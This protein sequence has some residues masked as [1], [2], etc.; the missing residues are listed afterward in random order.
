MACGLDYGEPRPRRLWSF[1]RGHGA[2][3][4]YSVLVITDVHL[5]TLQWP[6]TYDSCDY[7]TAP[8]QSVNGLPIATT[9]AGDQYNENLFSFLPGQKLSRCTC[10]GESHP[11]PMH[12]DG[13]YVGRSAPEIDVLEA[14]VRGLCQFLR[15]R[16]QIL[17]SFRS[18]PIQ[19]LV[20][21]WARSPNLVSLL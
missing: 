5:L 11:G 9:E 14:T 7:G 19:I 6:Y 20:L 16:K 12:S 10:S 18:L 2:N 3:S 15:I 4:L 1:S 17:G 8:N 21:Q 13:S